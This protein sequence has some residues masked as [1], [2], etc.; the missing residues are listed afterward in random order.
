MG[1]GTESVEVEVEM[2]IGG[3]RWGRKRERVQGETMQWGTISGMR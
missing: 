1:K 2:R 3:I